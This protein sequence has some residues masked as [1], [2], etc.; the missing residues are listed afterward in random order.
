MLRGNLATRPFYNERL[1]SLV[2][3]LV[4]AGVVALG[5]FN[6]SQFQRLSAHRSELNARI[7]RDQAE[8]DRIKAD[9][10]RVRQSVD[11]VAL[12]KLAVETHDANL[13][14][15]QRTFSWTNFFGVI[16]DTLP[17]DVRLQTISPRV[18]K[19]QFLMKITAV[20]KT[21]ADLD[22]FLERLLKTGMFR[23]PYWTD[24]N[25]TEDGSQVGILQ[26]IYRPA[27]D[28]EVGRGAPPPGRGRGAPAPGGRGRGGRP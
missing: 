14:I 19:G 4:A 26:A 18:E 16:E 11:Y 25:Q 21:A 15:D 2:L 8:V 3:L 24:F 27:A 6:Y 9:T 10:A 28:P 5:W 22:E 23:D 17:Y 1:V 7:E 12:K 13:L 20:G